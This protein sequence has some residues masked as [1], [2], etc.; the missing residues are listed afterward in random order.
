MWA[1]L[2]TLMGLLVAG[3]NQFA[4]KTQL[5]LSQNDALLKIGQVADY[6][7]EDILEADPL[8]I[9][10]T[11][12]TKITFTKTQYGTTNVTNCQYEYDS[13]SQGLKRTEI[14]P[15]TT[16]VKIVLPAV[17]APT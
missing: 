4:H 11:D 13:S 8:S 12:P 1:T 16:T 7:K 17:V 10:V 5:Q 2:V 14:T 9:I 3:V 15:S 6:I